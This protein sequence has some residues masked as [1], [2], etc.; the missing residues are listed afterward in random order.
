[1]ELTVVAAEMA[2]TTAIGDSVAIDGCCLT[3]VAID[4]ERISFFAGP[5]T[6]R[7]TTL[8]TLTGGDSVNVE[9][10]LR[11][12]EPLGGHYVQGHVDAVGTVA[13][14]DDEGDGMRLEVNLPPTLR[15]YTVEKG[16]IT[17]DG[18]SL[19]VAALTETGV[20][21]ALIPQTLAATTLAILRPGDPVNIEVDIM[22]KY[23]ERLLGSQAQPPG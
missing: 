21:L 23:V 20:A 5:E 2:P 3:A 13:G 4:G 11:A 8:S 7:K 1:M 14:A 15:R 10:A 16:S 19:T 22:A 6:L 18:V 9:P 12:G 17:V